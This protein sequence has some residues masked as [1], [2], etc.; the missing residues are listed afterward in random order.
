MFS[1]FRQR[2]RQVGQ[3]KRIR[4]SA[5]VWR[6]LIAK[7]ASS[8]LKVQEFCQREGLNASVFWRWRSRLTRSQGGGQVR[9]RPQPVVAPFI[10]LGDLRSSGARLEVRVELGAGV[11]LSI[12]RG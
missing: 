10:D 5:P 3:G 8:G 1:G 7:Q 9:A 11:V 12:A 4:R 2:E 6:E